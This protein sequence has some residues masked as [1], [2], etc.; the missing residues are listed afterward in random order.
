MCFALEFPGVWDLGGCVIACDVWGR[1]LGFTSDL[2]VFVVLSGFRVLL[3][4][5]FLS[6][7]ICGLELGFGDCWI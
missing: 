5:W 6:G 2:A 1:F 7:L 4:F 3:N